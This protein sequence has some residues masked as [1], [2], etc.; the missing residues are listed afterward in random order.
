M[1][2]FS[3]SFLDDIE[4]KRDTQRTS[5]R[6]PLAL[7]R[8][9][10]EL[11]FGSFLN[12][13]SS[14]NELNIRRQIIANDLKDLV[15]STCNELS[16]SDSDSILASVEASLG[17][18]HEARR[19][20]M[21]PFHRE[22]TDLS[23]SLGDANS[24]I[25]ALSQH[26]F[27]ESSCRG[28]FDG[29]CNWKADMLTQDYWDKRA[30]D[31]EE[32]RRER[33]EQWNI[34]PEGLPED[35]M[36]RDENNPANDNLME[37]LETNYQGVDIQE[38]L[39][40]APTA[41]GVGETGQLPDE[42]GDVSSDSGPHSVDVLTDSTRVSSRHT[43]CA[44]GCGDTCKCGSDCSCAECKNKKHSSLHTADGPRGNAAVT[45]DS[46]EKNE[47]PKMK[48]NS[49]ASYATGLSRKPE[50]VMD[51]RKWTPDRVQKPDVK[52]MGGESDYK[53]VGENTKHPVERQDISQPTNYT[54]TG[55]FEYDHRF[56]NDE[57]SG[58]VH[59]VQELPSAGFDD[60]GFND[61]EK[62]LNAENINP[63]TEQW[64]G[65]DGNG[66]DVQRQQ[67]PV[68]PEPQFDV[69][70]SSNFLH[71]EAAEQAIRSYRGRS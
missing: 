3:F 46:I 51:K 71:R 25:S 67:D 66:S 58:D 53:T 63:G 30:Q 1:N 20:K 59:Q 21:C 29:T 57:M 68:T 70:L 39:E 38:A 4:V 35:S 14:E 16:Y 33:E 24:A 41:V 45:G 22:L 50:P 34:K 17:F 47:S 64:T 13:A 7:A 40:H 19:P 61:S 62:I 11:R 60:A 54:G 10:A 37:D 52:T 31:L 27:G 55:L 44:C 12:E 18:R 48:N 43:A 36:M 26:M 23:L 15:E 5:A 28:A 42:G 56:L 9:R 2:S 32:R 69:I 8:R 6:Q 49:D 65:T